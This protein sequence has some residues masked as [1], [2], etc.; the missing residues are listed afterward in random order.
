MVFP[1]ASTPIHEKW[2]V[3]NVYGLHIMKTSTSIH[4]YITEVGYNGHMGYLARLLGFT[5]QVDSVP[6]ECTYR[7]YGVVSTQGEESVS[8]YGF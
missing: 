7:R 2:Y 5:K 4:M 6:H 8:S 3:G 1:L